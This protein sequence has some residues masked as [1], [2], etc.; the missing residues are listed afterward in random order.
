[1]DPDPEA[2]T[3]S[4]LIIAASLVASAFFSGLELAYVSANRLQIELDAKQS[5]RGRLI[6]RLIARPQLFIG[7]MLVGNNLALVFCGL[8]TGKLLGMA[9]FGTPDWTLAASPLLALSS[10][11][12]ATTVIIATSATRPTTV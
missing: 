2:L 8:E 3:G 7:S 6:A 5:F 10:Q 9:L 11:T 4:L 1:M 12:A